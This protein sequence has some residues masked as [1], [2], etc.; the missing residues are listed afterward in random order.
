MDTI[1][2]FLFIDELYFLY[3]WYNKHTSLLIQNT[4][5]GLWWIDLFIK[6][7]Y[8]Q[9]LFDSCAVLNSTSID[10]HNWNLQNLVLTQM[11]HKLGYDVR[12]ILSLSQRGLEFQT[13]D[14]AFCVGVYKREEI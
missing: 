11:R 2:A 12:I 13:H 6:L 8:F 5:V 10:L 14:E 4:V 9:L 3:L 7:N 1:C